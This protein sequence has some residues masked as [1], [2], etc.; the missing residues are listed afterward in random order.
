MF[1]PSRTRLVRPAI[2]AKP[3]SG[4]RTGVSGTSESQTPS[5]PLASSTSAKP[6]IWTPSCA[7]PAGATANRTFI[8]R[9]PVR[10]WQTGRIAVANS[11]GGF[12]TFEDSKGLQ[13][14]DLRPLAS[15]FGTLHL[16]HGALKVPVTCA[17]PAHG[18]AVHL[19]L[20]AEQHTVTHSFHVGPGK[21]ETLSF[22]LPASELSEIYAAKHTVKGAL[23]I[24][25]DM[26]GTSPDRLV[27]HPRL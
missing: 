16:V 7:S 6:A 8:A 1:A 23:T 26:P 25:T 11:G 17:A 3:S 13:V 2:I 9:S 21:S 22:T 10:C 5:K 4:S 20:A 19:S 12:V 24:T 27:V 18:C 15:Q 14:A